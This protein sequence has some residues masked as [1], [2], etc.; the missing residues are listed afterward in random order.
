MS[1]KE[2]YGESLDEDN[3]DF[4]DEK[5]SDDENYKN[6]LNAKR[7]RSEMA[8]DLDELDEEGPKATKGSAA[9]KKVK[10]D[11]K[12]PKSVITLHFEENPVHEESTPKENKSKDT[13]A[14]KKKGKKSETKEKKDT[15]KSKAS[16][17]IETQPFDQA[18]P[19]NMK[20]E[21][22]YIIPKDEEN[23]YMET[24]S[25]GVTSSMPMQTKMEME[26]SECFGSLK[27]EVKTEPMD[28]LQN[29]AGGLPN[30]MNMFMGM[31]HQQQYQ[32]SQSLSQEQQ[33]Q[34]LREQI[35]QR[36]QPQNHL[37]TRMY[38]QLRKD[39]KSLPELPNTNQKQQQN[40]DP[41]QQFLEL[42]IMKRQQQLI[43]L[44]SKL[45]EMQEKANISKKDKPASQE[46]Q[47]ETKPAYSDLKNLSPIKTQNQ[48]FA[49]QIYFK[50]AQYPN[51][52][53][54]ENNMPIGHHLPQNYVRFPYP[55]GLQMGGQGKNQPG[56]PAAFFNYQQEGNLA[57][58]KGMFPGTK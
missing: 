48:S 45:K 34:E 23:S 29:F 18:T 17:K 31:Q 12:K 41:R 46:K 9:K 6:E 10:T 4:E 37:L 35:L 55:P 28:S 20:T 57:N 56:I 30:N 8:S 2:S 39:P 15:K 26:M 24:S 1:L 32:Q 36:P 22:G 58:N 5:N 53:I 50:N 3:D 47:N 16:A 27:R 14:P 25:I 44:Q 33:L 43:Q 13:S 38:E 21:S 42:Q 54:M 49:N 51:G 7:K 40:P 19:I 52:N 11:K